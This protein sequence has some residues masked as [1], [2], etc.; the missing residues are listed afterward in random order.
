MFPHVVV[1]VEFLNSSNDLEITIVLAIPN[2]SFD[3]KLAESRTTHVTKNSLTNNLKKASFMW[4]IR[5]SY[6]T[7]HIKNF[8]ISKNLH[9]LAP[10]LNCWTQL[11]VENTRSLYFKTDWKDITR[12][13]IEYY[14][15]LLYWDYLRFLGFIGEFRQFIHKNLIIYL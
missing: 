4:K 12:H 8:M 14:Y 3:T 15:T 6:N 5:Q 10:I 2:K 11:F 1:V 9:N 13:H 7:E